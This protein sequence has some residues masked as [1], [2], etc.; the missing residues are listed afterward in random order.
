MTTRTNSVLT[1]SGKRGAFSNCGPISARFTR[2]IRSQK[3]TQCGLPMLTQ[4][5]R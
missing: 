3:T 5:T 2:S 1:R 4:V